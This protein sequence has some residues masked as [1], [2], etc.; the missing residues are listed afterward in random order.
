MTAPTWLSDNAIHYRLLYSDPTTLRS[1]A[2]NRWASSPADLMDAGLRYILPPGSGHASGDAYV[3]DAQL[4]EFE[5]E[6]T[7]AHDAKVR[8]VLQATIRRSRDGQI[9]AEQ[10]FEMEQV[11]SPDVQGGITGLAQLAQKSQLAVAG[12]VK[13][14]LTASGSD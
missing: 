11:S 1:Y 9:I 2:D 5:Q 3:L 8:L 7:S 13:V 4:M 6:F 10:R 14:R 12:W